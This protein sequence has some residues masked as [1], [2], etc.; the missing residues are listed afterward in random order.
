MGKEEH[1]RKPPV[2]KSW[3]IAAGALVV[4]T[5]AV[6]FRS[7]EGPIASAPRFTAV[8]LSQVAGEN[9]LTNGGST[10]NERFSSLDQINVSNVSQLKGVFRTHL[11]TASTTGGLANQ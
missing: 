8:D 9:W 10:T 7:G 2:R 3:L 11:V 6:G 4:L 5:L 1:L